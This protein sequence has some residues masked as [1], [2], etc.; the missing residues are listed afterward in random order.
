M[1]EHLGR[2]VDRLWGCCGNLSRLDDANNIWGSARRP[3]GES[4]IRDTRHSSEDSP[5]DRPRTGRPLTV[6]IRISAFAGVVIAALFPVVVV[7]LQAGTAGGNHSRAAD[8][9][10]RLCQ[11]RQAGR[12]QA[13]PKLWAKARASK[14]PQAMSV[15]LDLIG[16]D[17]ELSASICETLQ[18]RYGLDRSHI[19]DSRRSHTH[20]DRRCDGASLRS[21]HLLV[22]TVQATADRCLYRVARGEEFRGRRRGDPCDAPARL[23]W[24]IGA[25]TFAVNR[26]GN[27]RGTVADR[28]PKGPVDHAV[29]VLAVRDPR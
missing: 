16:I 1:W 23:S 21:D 14:T 13:D 18:E 11:S 25:A 9:D 5:L 26:R 29:P 6:L 4:D 3:T 10:E 20:K 24:D 8:V 15:T 2:R 27:T 22:A 28:G 7:G 12:R 17:R 19:R